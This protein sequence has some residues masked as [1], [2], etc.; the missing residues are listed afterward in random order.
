MYNIHCIV[1]NIYCIVYN[2]HCIVYIVIWL[3]YNKHIVQL[4]RSHLYNRHCTM[5]NVYYTDYTDCSVY[6][7]QCKL[8]IYTVIQWLYRLN[9][10]CT[11]C[12]IVDLPFF[13][14]FT[15]KN[16]L[17]I[18]NDIYFTRLYLN[19]ILVSFK[20]IY[21]YRLF[22][23]IDYFNKYKFLFLKFNYYQCK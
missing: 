19:S 10:L 22:I 6:N 5:H 16:K 15:N 9:F 11:V 17:M 12:C 3:V 20:M 8:H 1:F 23:A 7:V 2:I 4:L 13:Y 21:L 14:L 18:S